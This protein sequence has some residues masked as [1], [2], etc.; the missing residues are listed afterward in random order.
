MNRPVFSARYWRI[1]ALS[2]IATGSPPPG[3]SRSTMAGIRL[4]GDNAR[5][6]GENCSPRPMFTG[7]TLY[8]RPHSSSMMEIFQ[9]FGVGQ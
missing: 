7:F 3:G 6:A 5:N 9:P 1:A 2:K 4:L 8:G